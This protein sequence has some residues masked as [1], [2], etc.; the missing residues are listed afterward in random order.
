MTGHTFKKKG[1]EKAYSYYK[2]YSRLQKGEMA[3]TGLSL[4]ANELEEFITDQLINLSA[5]KIFLSDKKK[6]LEV[7]RA[8]VDN[9]EDDSEGK[10]LDQEYSELTKRLD[11]LLDKMERRL[12][13]DEDFQP[14]YEKIKNDMGTLENER[15]KLIASGKSKQIALNS[16][17][18]SFE[19]IASFSKNWN[20]LDNTGRAL[21]IKS[22]IKEIRAT[23][24][25]IDLD[26]FLDVAKASRTDK[27]S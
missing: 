16:L 15:V 19:E 18:S 22:I 23:K 4:R 17:E 2:C 11:T 21:R 13:S 5:N 8:R 7:L 25:N 26:I 6:M 14:R 10:R 20:Y 27:G 24:D 12:I 3:C 9:D 1:T